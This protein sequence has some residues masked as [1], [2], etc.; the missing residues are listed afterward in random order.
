MAKIR[1]EKRIVFSS[2][3][4]GA[5]FQEDFVAGDAWKRAVFLKSFLNNE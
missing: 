4:K 2:F 3:L 1:D 5:P